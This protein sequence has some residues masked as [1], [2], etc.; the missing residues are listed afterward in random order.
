MT[1]TKVKTY[2]SYKNLFS[3]VLKNG[4][5]LPLSYL[6]DDS[7]IKSL[8]EDIIK[9]FDNYESISYSSFLNAIV[10][11]NHA[12]KS[13]EIGLDEIGK[14][15]LVK[16]PPNSGIIFHR[17]NLLFLIAELIKKNEG[18]E[19]I[20]GQKSFENAREYCKSLLLASQLIPD[21]S[22][23]KDHFIKTYPYYYIPKTAANIYELRLQ[24]YWYIYNELLEKTED[25]KKKHIKSGLQL[26]EEKTG[27]SLQEY[28]HA[29]A[30]LYYW[31]LKMPLLKEKY[32]DEQLQKLGF[33]FKNIDTF[34]IRKQ[35]FGD[36]HDLLKLI[37][38]LSVDLAGF[39]EKIKEGRRDG[40]EGFYKN[41]QTFFDYPVFKIDDNNFCIIDFKFLF[42][43]L[44]AGFLWHLNALI[45]TNLQS[46]REQ[47]GYLLESYFIEL[48][49]KI[50]GNEN[51]QK[52]EENGSPDAVL[53]TDEY[54]IIIE[55]TTEY[56]RF[57]SL[58]N[59]GTEFLKDDLHRLLFNK[60][61]KDEKSRGKKESG[62]FFKLNSYVENYKKN[63]KKNIPVLVTE[64]YLG[65]FDL[66]NRFDSCL[67]QEIKAGNLENLKI[68]K[69]VILNIDDFELFWQVADRK[70]S[71]NQLGQYIEDWEENIENKGHYH[72][73]FSFFVSGKSKDLEV[74]EEFPTFFSFQSFIENLGK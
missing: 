2:L 38:H 64:N 5:V 18:K 8:I 33:D 3:E 66:L 52:P 61:I 51:V 43:G 19:K 47:Y 6:E 70:K 20:T 25:D 56:Y 69:P 26:L 23:E 67:N 16:N 45:T 65:D 35:N 63:G 7:N 50:F 54:V 74:N 49:R 1:Q 10:Q 59:D 71:I 37:N 30:T 36:D 28:F 12:E 11:T 9:E 24:R 53:E 22:L 29:I 31:Y 32:A 13:E 60:G 72:F 44:C 46:I 21:S 14:I 42:D 17:D 39:K 55:F 57:S 62:K 4:I 58:Y 48:L 68:Y 15:N 73:N 41:F 40:I 27:L 34:Y